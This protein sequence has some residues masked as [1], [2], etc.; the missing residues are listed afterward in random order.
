MD[1]IDKRII[2]EL[3]SDCRI[4]FQTLANKLDLS[5]TAVRKR[6]S[7]LLELGIID[8]FLTTLSLGMIDSDLL[9]AVVQTDGS[10]YQD[11]F[12]SEIGKNPSVAQVSH[13]VCGRGGLYCVFAVTSGTEALSSFGMYMRTMKS[14][15]NVE[16]HVLIY[17]KGEKIELTKLQLRVLNHL[18]D[19]PR[20]SIVELAES[21]GLTARRVR[22]IVEELQQG[23]AI[24]FSIFWN[25]GKGGLTEALL[26]IEV[27]ETVSSNE[28]IIEMLHK[29]YPLEF[30]TPFV[31]ATSP[32]IFARFVVEEL[33]TIEAIARQVRKA[34]FVKTLST[35][36]FFSNNVYDWPGVTELR[37]LLEDVK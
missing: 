34:P 25:M 24:N 36:V 26:R 27:D 15:T 1:D 33:E 35:L 32:V 20:I 13:V 7:K 28:S 30:W 17:P 19:N 22:R 14:V 3:D 31:S 11:E 6:I 5:A 10:E 37:R 2:L 16:I 18:I 23:N 8:H 21:S 9:L 12:I 29:D 4:T